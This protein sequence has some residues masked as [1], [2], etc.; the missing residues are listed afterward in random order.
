MLPQLGAL[1]MLVT[2][3]AHVS[4]MAR[5]QNKRRLRNM[6]PAGRS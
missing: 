2:T 4:A 3:V 5:V 6:L 1:F